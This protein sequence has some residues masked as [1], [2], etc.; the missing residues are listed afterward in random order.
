MSFP[1]APHA[2][3]DLLKNLALLMAVL[4]LVFSVFSLWQSVDANGQ[5]QAQT[6][7]ATPMPL[8]QPRL[9]ALVL[10]GSFCPDCW[11]ADSTVAALS[12]AASVKKELV[13][14][15]TTQSAALARRYNVTRAPAIVVTGEIDDSRLR[16]VFGSGWSRRAD[17]YVFEAP[18][19]AYF[20]PVSGQVTGRVRLTRV[21]EPSCTVCADLAPL[22]DNLR[23]AGVLIATDEQF[24]ASSAQGVELMRKYNVTALPFLVLSPD[25][26]AYPSIVQAWSGAGTIESDGYF[27]WRKAVPPYFNVTSGRTE[28]LVNVTELSDASCASCYNVTVHRAVL[29]NFGVAVGNVTRLDVA[30]SLGRALV[31]KY[32]I[33]QVPTVLLS[34]D[35]RV[36]DTL[37]QVWA[38]VGTVEPDGTYVFRNMTALGNVTAADVAR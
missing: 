15:N 30:S 32:A 35:A 17:A 21:I 25:A 37:G 8:P 28:G 29:A 16:S 38:Q 13:D 18:A 12:A 14:S 34:S 6:A 26:S 23:Q 2:Q 27:V 7:L 33:R 20:D 31:T 22:S 19:P 5:F 24:N 4:A 3:T 36:Y 10:V 1:K 9:N 11:N